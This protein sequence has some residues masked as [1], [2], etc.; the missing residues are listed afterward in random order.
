MIQGSESHLD[1]FGVRLV[2]VEIDFG[3]MCFSDL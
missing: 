3:H 2:E 1:E